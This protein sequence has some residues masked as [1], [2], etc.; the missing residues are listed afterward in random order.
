MWRKFCPISVCALVLTGARSPE[1][2]AVRQCRQDA[3]RWQLVFSDEE[4]K[5]NSL[6]SVVSLLEGSPIH[7]TVDFA[8]LNSDGISLARGCIQRHKDAGAS[9][10]ALYG[11]L[12]ASTMPLEFALSSVEVDVDSKLGDM[13]VCGRRWDARLSRFVATE[14]PKFV[15]FAVDF[16][17]VNVNGDGRDVLPVA[18]GI[19]NCLAE[20]SSCRDKHGKMNTSDICEMRR[21]LIGRAGRREDEGCGH[22]LRLFGEGGR[23][24]AVGAWLSLALLD[25][26]IAPGDGGV[27]RKDVAASIFNSSGRFMPPISVE[28]PEAQSSALKRTFRNERHNGEKG[29]NR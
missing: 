12:T 23:V 26:H 20:R 17:L 8:V 29:G 16:F 27:R 5:T 11:E 4:F 19:A 7:R 9:Y 14:N 15:W 28:T 18:K 24:T 3:T 2:T 21:I 25:E 1:S 22:P 13:C 10:S 6:A